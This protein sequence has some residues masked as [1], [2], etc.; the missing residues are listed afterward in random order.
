[1]ECCEGLFFEGAPEPWFDFLIISNGFV[2]FVLSLLEDLEVREG[3]RRS[4]S[5]KT[6]S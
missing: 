6:S 1:L 2:Q 3:N 4:R 5:A